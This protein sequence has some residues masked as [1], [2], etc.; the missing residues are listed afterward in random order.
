MNRTWQIRSYREGDERQIVQLRKSVFGDID[1]VRLNLSAWNW[2]FKNN[3]AGHA[4]IFL[5]EDHGKIV[6]QYTAIPTRILWKGSAYVFAFSCDTMTHPDYRN[7][8]MFSGLAGDLYHFISRQYNVETVWGFPNGQSLPGFTKRL[9]WKVIARYP[10]RIIPLR[11]LRML[12]SFYRFYHHP[13]LPAKPSNPRIS[14][15]YEIDPGLT[16]FPIREFS[17]EFDEI[18]HRHRPLFRIVQIRDSRYLNWRYGELPEF[19]YVSFAVKHHDR[20]AGYLVIRL[21]TLKGH[22]FGALMDM[23]PIPMIDD[24]V[25]V[26][27]LRFV[28]RFCRT[29]RAEFIALLL[30][31]NVRKLLD[32]IGAVTIPDIINPRPWILGCRN[33]VNHLENRPDDWHVTYGD[34]D[35]L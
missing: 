31:G 2:Q 8:G 13:S 25:T 15:A 24:E 12:H 22:Y 5:A 19:G 3:P 26:Q 32:R 28:R 27:L 20:L 17:Q 34:A 33:P 11:P 6:G 18:W 4:W 23:F 10:L 35:I 14:E 9:N 29:N 21:M 16:L 7:Q 30:P 1:P